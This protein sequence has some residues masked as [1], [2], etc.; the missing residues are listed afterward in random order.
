MDI[1]LF[2]M[3]DRIWFRLLQSFIVVVFL[4]A[5]IYEIRARICPP[6]PAPAVQRSEKS[7]RLIEFFWT[8]VTIILVEI[9]ISSNVVAGCTVFVGLLNF[10][11]L[12]LINFI[13]SYF[14]NKIVGWMS[15]LH[16]TKE[17]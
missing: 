4:I 3:S 6:N 12:L 2:I 7:W 1:F 16:A 10:I 13:S 17:H 8:I 9:I 14:R 5:L 15:R 11:M